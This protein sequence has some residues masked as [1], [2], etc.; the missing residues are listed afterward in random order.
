MARCKSNDEQLAYVE[1]RTVCLKDLD[2]N[3]YFNGIEITD[4]MRFFKG[5]GPAVE[6]ESGQ[7]KGG[8]F[9]CICGIH[10]DKVTELDHAFRCPMKTVDERQKTV[11]EGS[12][13]HQ[14]TLNKKPKPFANLS[15]ADIELEVLERKLNWRQNMTKSELQFELS[16][17]LSGIS[18][19]PAL[20]YSTP[21]ET[22]ENLN[23]QFYDILPSES[24]HDIAGHISNIFEESPN[25][26]SKPTEKSKRKQKAKETTPD[27]L[28]MIINLS[29]EGKEVKLCV[30][31]RLSLLKVSHY[32]KD[33]FEE[34][35][36]NL[37]LMLDTLVEIQA[38]LYLPEEE[39]TPRTILR[40]HNLTFL[41]AIMCHSIFDRKNI[42]SMMYRKF[43]GKYYHGLITHAPFQ[44]RL[45]SGSASNAEDE[46]RVF[47]KIKRITANTSSNHPGHII[48]NL[49]IR[50]QVEQKHA[51][52]L[53]EDNEAKTVQHEISKLYNA[54]DKLPNTVVPY[55]FIARKP[56]VWQAHLERIADFLLPGEGVWWSQEEEGICF[57]DGPQEPIKHIEGPQ[58]HH[59]RS[60]TL[61]M[62][63]EYLQDC[64]KSILDNKIPVPIHEIISDK[65]NGSIK[66]TA[67]DFVKALAPDSLISKT[68]EAN[69]I[70]QTPYTA[71]DYCE[72]Q[73]GNLEEEDEVVIGF[74]EHDPVELSK[75]QYSAAELSQLQHSAGIESNMNSSDVTGFK[76]GLTH[77]KR[78]HLGSHNSHNQNDMSNIEKEISPVKESEPENE[79]KQIHPPST[80]SSVLTS[81]LPL[82]TSTP[83]ASKLAAKKCTM[84]APKSY[85]FPGTKLGKA[86]LKVLGDDDEVRSLDKCRHMSKQ[87]PNDKELQDLYMEK[88]AAIQTRVSRAHSEC[89]TLFKK[90]DQEFFMNKGNDWASPSDQDIEK[91]KNISELM[92]KIKYAKAL[93]REWKIAL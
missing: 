46:E 92:Q 59:F 33:R 72:E 23:L 37:Q 62:E 81:F 2:K 83:A 76:S 75:V 58:M 61:K 52:D 82:C 90:W 44:Y 51:K 68:V 87:Q 40:L 16:Q 19:V 89:I 15:K 70:D 49:F 30:D 60:S 74:T 77:Y 20:F 1:T 3:L 64:W 34:K 9:Y 27:E 66:R 10:S 65:G 39:R 35:D 54:M 73:Q 50:F 45:I 79:Q 29:M 11:L 8:Y 32:M 25:H 24:M 22:L 48:G 31:Y 93:L 26:I 78:T 43:Y 28:K 4:R 86:I 88:L 12:V 67:T 84:E 14:N 53:K 85:S 38:I 91:D 80:F 7:Q 36:Q 71:T 5:D 57:I 63:A 55:E 18:R 17:E 6:Y 21:L 56:R 42:K 41:H 13:G 69:E 47:N